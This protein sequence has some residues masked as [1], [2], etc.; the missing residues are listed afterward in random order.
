M[1]YQD[2]IETEAQGFTL[3]PQ[4]ITSL[5]DVPAAFAEYYKKA[6]DGSFV[7]PNTISTQISEVVEQVRADYREKL[8]EVETQ[9][10]GQLARLDKHKRQ[11]ASD[12]IADRLRPWLDD[13]NIHPDMMKAVTK[14]IEKELH[15]YV[16][17]DSITDDI[18]TAVVK[19][20]SHGGVPVSFLLVRHAMESPVLQ[21]FKNSA[22]PSHEAAFG[23]V[24]ALLDTAK[25]KRP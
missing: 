20:K 24:S 16:D 14:L 10:Q 13:Y 8:A 15:L 5:D 9:N 6:D 18:T 7:M 3:P 1:P 25:G 22:A 2:T 19:S 23:A 21:P 17:E 4:R 11:W 12:T